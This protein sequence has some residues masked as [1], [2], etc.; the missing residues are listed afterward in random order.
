MQKVQETVKESPKRA[1]VIWTIK[2]KV[3]ETNTNNGR[4]RDAGKDTATKTQPFDE[5]MDSKGRKGT[6]TCCCCL[7]F[8]HE[9]WENEMAREKLVINTHEKTKGHTA[10]RARRG[11]EEIMWNRNRSHHVLVYHSLSFKLPPLCTCEGKPQWSRHHT[12][13]NT[14]P[15]H[16]ISMFRVSRQNRTQHNTL[17]L[18]LFWP[19]FTFFFSSKKMQTLGVLVEK[20]QPNHN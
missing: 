10:G 6:G 12:C 3:F 17:S 16:N 15:R 11:C 1:T 7:V 18:S 9:L 19:T 2:G 5:G 13:R 4:V 20:M 14:Q 8:V